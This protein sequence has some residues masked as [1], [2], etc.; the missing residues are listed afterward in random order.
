MSLSKTG[1]NHNLFGSKHKE[2][3][4]KK[5]SESQKGIKNHFY[6]KHH[7][8]LT[9]EIGRASCRERV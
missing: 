4:K 9:I 3:T 2:S 5:M 8:S 7:R 1:K 6:G